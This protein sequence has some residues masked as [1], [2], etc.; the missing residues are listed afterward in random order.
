MSP[1][2]ALT[3]RVTMKL[4]LETRSGSRMCDWESFA[5]LRD[6]VQHF[7][8]QGLPQERFCALHALERAVDEGACRVDASRLRG[9][10][11]RAWSALWPKTYGEA[12]VSPRTRAILMDAPGAPSNTPTVAARQT[13]WNLP[14]SAPPELPIPKAAA[15][16]L[17][18]VLTLTSKAQDGD[19]L[20]VRRVG[21]APAFVRAAQHGQD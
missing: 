11:L 7:L 3:G 12:A 4:V 5:F 2:R 1:E 15:S 14:L 21:Q 8:E 9:E 10:V 18:A 17:N 19:W 6:N 16:F 20:E 13:D